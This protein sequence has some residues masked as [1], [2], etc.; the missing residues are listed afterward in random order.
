M[1]NRQDNELSMS[2][3]TNKPAGV[4]DTLGLGFETVLARPLLIIPPVFLDLYLWLGVH[5]TSEP[6]M[7]RI[8]EWLRRQGLAGDE[9]V[10]TIEQNGTRNISELVVLWMPTVR[11]PSFLAAVPD[12][13]AYRLEAWRPVW[14]LSSWGIAFLGAVLIVVGLI[15]GVEYLLAIAS[16]IALPD[17]E[18]KRSIGEGTLRATWN[19]VSWYIV[20]ALLAILILWPILAAYVAAEI[21]GTG[22]SFWL[23]LMLLLPVSWGFVLFF[24]SVQAMFIDQVGPL[25]AL[26]SSY[27]VVRND[28]WNS[29][30]IIFSY[31]LLTVGFPQV[32]VL[33]AD[34]PL[35][36]LIAIIGHACIGTGMIAAT[37]VFYRDRVQHLDVA[38]RI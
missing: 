21:F 10:S 18:R 20:V 30:G 26:R 34:Q 36:L 13:T 35:G 16:A 7:M 12:E 3:P 31:F 24:F 32:W 4:I 11:V 1:W 5:I 25:Q 17:R 28:G 29:L 33:I 6:L 37:M 27:R 14:S 23:V 8:G 38:G 2:D 22:S 19:V 9:A 15:V